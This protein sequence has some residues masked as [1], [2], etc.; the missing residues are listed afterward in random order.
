M[1]IITKMGKWKGLRQRDM[2]FDLM[3]YMPNQNN[4]IQV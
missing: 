4:V 2:S 1:D 3:A